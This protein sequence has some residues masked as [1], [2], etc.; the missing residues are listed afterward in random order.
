MACIDNA[1][2]SHLSALKQPRWPLERSGHSCV[3][4]PKYASLSS[5]NLHNHKYTTFLDLQLRV[6]GRE[7]TWLL[8]VMCVFVVVEGHCRQPAP[9]HRLLVYVTVG[10][11]NFLFN[12]TEFP[13]ELRFFIANMMRTS[14]INDFSSF[15]RLRSTP[16]NSLIPSKWWT[17]NTNVSLS[18]L[19]VAGLLV[20]LIARC[21][22]TSS[23][24]F[25]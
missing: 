5:H 4:R 9:L 3:V 19:I 15:S 20:L 7:T 11:L 14:P 6:L 2:F 12:T 1:D 16:L 18:S 10:K 8:I 24:F 17:G 25:S 21:F 22:I 23:L 13:I